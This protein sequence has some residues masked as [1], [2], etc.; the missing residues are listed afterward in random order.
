[1][2]KTKRYE[3]LEDL[4]GDDMPD[5][6]KLQVEEDTIFSKDR[7]NIGHILIVKNAIEKGDELT[8]P[9]SKEEFRKIGDFYQKQ[10]EA[11]QGNHKGN[12]F[13]RIK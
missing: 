2:E 1:M 4:I 9:G 12:L 7:R 3:F 11:G 8:L 13:F 10:A 6:D 5:I